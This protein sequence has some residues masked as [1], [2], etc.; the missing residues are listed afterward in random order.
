MFLLIHTTC[1]V[2]KGTKEQC[3]S[4]LDTLVKKYKHPKKHFMIILENEYLELWSKKP[5]V[6]SQE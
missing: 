1:P 6:K 4:L 3:E 5:C 2:A